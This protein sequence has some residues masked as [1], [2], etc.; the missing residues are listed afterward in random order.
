P[1]SR[2]RRAGPFARPSASSAAS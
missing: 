1:T 2:S